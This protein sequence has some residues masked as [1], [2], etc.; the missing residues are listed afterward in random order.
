MDYG[1]PGS[2]IHGIFQ[3]RILEWFA[4][5][6]SRGELSR[7]WNRDGKWENNCRTQLRRPHLLVS[8]DHPIYTHCPNTITT[9]VPFHLSKPSWLRQQILRTTL[10]I[11]GE[12][13]WRRNLAELWGVGR[14]MRK[15]QPSGAHLGWGRGCRG[16]VHAGSRGRSSCFLLQAV[17]SHWG[18]LSKVITELGLRKGGQKDTGGKERGLKSRCRKHGGPGKRSMKGRGINTKRLREGWGDTVRGKSDYEWPLGHVS[19]SNPLPSLTDRDAFS[20]KTLP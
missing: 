4:I 17:A 19:K 13:A 18:F 7:G 10:E 6:F 20:S 14:V 16:G 3:A 11:T 15:S 8:W 2:P 5:S 9:S 12:K 1:L